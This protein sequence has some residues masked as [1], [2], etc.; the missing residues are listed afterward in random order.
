MKKLIFFLLVGLAIVSCDSEDYG[1]LPH[2]GVVAEDQSIPFEEILLTIS[3]KTPDGQY[4][5]V[6][7]IDSVNIYVNNKFWARLNSQQVDV[8]KVEKVQSG[9]RYLSPNKI[10]YLV[11]ARQDPASLPSFNTAGDFSRYLN[12]LLELRAGEYACFVESF[13]ITLNDNSV[14]TIYPYQYRIFK[15]EQNMRSVYVGEIEI[16]IES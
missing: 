7:S 15:I 6:Q 3:V 12:S 5:V 2:R 1:P 4:L 11:I 13:T 16:I 14:R 8:S 10:Q 9:N